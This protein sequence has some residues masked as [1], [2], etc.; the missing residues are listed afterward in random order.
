M[1]TNLFML[2]VS[3]CHSGIKTSS[4]GLQYWISWPSKQ[5][6]KTVVLSQH[7]QTQRDR[8]DE[9]NLKKETMAKGGKEVAGNESM[10]KQVMKLT[11]TEGARHCNLVPTMNDITK[12][13][14]L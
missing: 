1:S 3:M 14:S 12:Y 4:A 9:H 10:I 11:D 5:V 13:M 8:A 7:I 6:I 2:S